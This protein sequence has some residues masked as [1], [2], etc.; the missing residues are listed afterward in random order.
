MPFSES[1][2]RRP[3]VLA[4]TG[5]S[6]SS[7]Y[8]MIAEGRFPAPRRIGVRAVAWNAESVRT[9]ID[10]RPLAFVRGSGK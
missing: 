8:A 9:W 1:L 6:K 7:L 2:M 10:T 3:E 4:V 5:L